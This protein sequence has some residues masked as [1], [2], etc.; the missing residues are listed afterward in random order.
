M[1]SITCC[2]NFQ[3]LQLSVMFFLLLAVVSNWLHHAKLHIEIRRVRNA[4]R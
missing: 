4:I 1:I 3:I 2:L